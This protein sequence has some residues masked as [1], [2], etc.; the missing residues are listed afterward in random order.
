MVTLGVAAVLYEFGQQVEF[1]GGADGLQGIVMGPLLGRFEF[2]LYGRTAYAYSL[3]TLIVVM[4]IAR[5]VV[6]IRPSAIPESAARHR[7]RAT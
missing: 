3:V 4:L 2:D 7:L 6:V 1:T 5:R